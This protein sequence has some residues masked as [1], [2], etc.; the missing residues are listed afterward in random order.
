MIIVKLTKMVLVISEA[1]LI[2]LLQKDTA[3]LA[4]CIKRGKVEKRR[5]QE[6]TYR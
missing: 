1:E 3:L 2:K 5:C 6:L 4:K